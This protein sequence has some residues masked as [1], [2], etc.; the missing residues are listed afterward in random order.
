MNFLERGAQSRLMRRTTLAT[1]WFTM[2][3]PGCFALQLDVTQPFDDVGYFI[4]FLPCIAVITGA[5]MEAVM[6]GSRSA[7]VVPT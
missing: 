5:V 2:I 7:R 6:R 1:G 4:A 3:V